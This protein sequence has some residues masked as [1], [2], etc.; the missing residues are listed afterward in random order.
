MPLFEII[1]T[2]LH[3]SDTTAKVGPDVNIWLK[4]LNKKRRKQTNKTE[5]R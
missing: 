5:K 4:A 2:T 1:I 3:V